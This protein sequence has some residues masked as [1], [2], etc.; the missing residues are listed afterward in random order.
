MASA[1]DPVTE[2]EVP[3]GALEVSMES[4]PVGGRNAVV[5]ALSQPL[6]MQGA[7]RMRIWI[8]S[9]TVHQRAT[10]LHASVLV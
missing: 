4:V 3:A 2:E 1:A 8:A 7:A 6:A 10:I 9:G 5:A